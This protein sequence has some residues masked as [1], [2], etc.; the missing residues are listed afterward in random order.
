MDDCSDKEM[1]TS[2]VVATKNSAK[3]IKECLSSL[4]PYYK[5]GYI[6]EIVV[7]DGYSSDGTLEVAKSFPV[8]L[9]FEKR[10]GLSIAYEVGWRNASGELIL[11]IDSDA[12]LGDGFFPKIYEF[13]Q[14]GNVG[15][16]GVQ[17]QTVISNRLS[18]IVAQWDTYH[19]DKIRKIQSNASLSW[20]ERL[21]RKGVWFGEPQIV[22]T[23]PCYAAR[24]SALEAVEG[25][26]PYQRIG[27]EDY[28]LSER[29]TQAGRKATW[30]LGTPVY[31]Y[32][33]PS[34]RKLEK[35]YFGWG[36]RDTVSWKGYYKPS[37]FIT[38][39][40]KYLAA[41]AIGLICAFRFRNPLH[42]PLFTLVKYTQL[43]GYIYGLVT[44]AKPKTKS[45]S[46]RVQG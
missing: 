19:S 12:Y 26:L 33:R 15:I 21:Y 34:L 45:D 36:L 16:V 1:N 3:T 13:F 29:I 31:H 40:L 28:N 41:P 9:L 2:V 10:R 42:L 22:V 44:S 4:M 27:G 14:D 11:F 35:Q 23:G 43:V 38:A 18:R 37:R 25:F 5:Q 6:K 17:A 30:W 7:V 39:G 32:P 24:R 46:L 8:K 20:F